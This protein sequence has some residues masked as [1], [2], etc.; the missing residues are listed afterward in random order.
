MSFTQWAAVATAVAAVGLAVADDRHFLQSGRAEP[1]LIFILDTSSSMVGSPEVVGMNWPGCDPAELVLDTNDDGTPDTADPARCLNG[2]L[3]SSGMVPG[4][5]DDPYSRMGI[6]KKVLRD[7]LEDVNLA[8][9]ALAGYAQ[10]KPT[11]PNWFDGVPQKHWV[12]EARAQDRFHMVEPGYAYR[13]GYNESFKGLY[14]DVPADI[15]KKKLIGYNLFF[16]PASTDVPSRFGAVR[17]D[18]TGYRD[19]LADGS[20]RPA[21][22]DLMPLYFGNSFWDA[23]HP[24]TPK[25]VYGWGVFPFYDAGVRSLDAGSFGDLIPAMWYYGDAD[26]GQ[27]DYPGCDPT[28]PMWDRNGDGSPDPDA[29]VSTWEQD[30]GGGTIRHFQRRVRLEIPDTYDSAANHF[31]EIDAAGARSGNKQITDGGSED[32]DQ[33]THSDPDLDGDQSYDWMLYVNS[34]EETREIDCKPAGQLPTWTYTPTKT[35]EQYC[36]IEITD[37]KPEWVDPYDVTTLCDDGVG[38]KQF[39]LQGRVGRDL[40]RLG[41]GP[42]RHGLRQPSVFWRNAEYRPRDGGLL[43]FGQQILG[44]QHRDPGGRRR[45]VPA[46]AGRVQGVSLPRRRL[47]C[48]FGFPLRWLD[49]AVVW[50]AE[51]VGHGSQRR[52][53]V[54]LRFRPPRCRA[55]WQRRRLPM[56]QHLRRDLRWQ[57]RVADADQNADPHLY[58]NPVW[59]ADRHP[60]RAHAAADAYADDH[61]HQTA[62]ADPTADPGADGHTHL[63]TDADQ[64]ADPDHHRL[65]GTGEHHEISDTCPR[66]HAAVN[67]GTDELRAPRRM[68]P[69]V[70][71][72]TCLRAGIRCPGA[73]C[74]PGGCDRDL[75]R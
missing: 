14:L 1:N 45:Q 13:F 63:H 55:R 8:N 10:E 18:Q 26:P 54:V 59:C 17:G 23:N 57:R 64:N 12:Y 48:G 19:T 3:V 5:G 22:Y 44:R 66:N 4:A 56:R 60:R 67:D 65:T 7:F 37:F 34:V 15:Y 62:A 32:Y 27:E 53:R 74:L 6:A 38:Q 68:G 2:A 11:D 29:C 41:P 73:G 35:W 47:R 43:E 9:V 75:F 24:T 33:D 16:N 70:H 36:Q 31:I 46:A 72:V 25:T 71:S 42:P 51:L 40:F 39:R 28:D 21:P 52:L 50:R 30:V 61:P 49:A 69:R 20:E 58:P